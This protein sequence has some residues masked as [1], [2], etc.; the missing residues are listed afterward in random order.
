MFG[1]VIDVT[2]NADAGGWFHL[3]GELTLFNLLSAQMF[4]PIFVKFLR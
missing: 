4:L 3:V 1:D 2:N